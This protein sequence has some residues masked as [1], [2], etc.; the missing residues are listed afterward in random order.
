MLTLGFVI[1]ITT[2]LAVAVSFV[3]RVFINSKGNIQM[4][5]YTLQDF[6]L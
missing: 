5:A 4:L 6:L 2:L 1:S 3:I